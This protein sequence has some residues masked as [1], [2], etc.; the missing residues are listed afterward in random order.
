M[1]G[2]IIINHSEGTG[3]VPLEQA[4]VTTVKTEEVPV[5]N[6]IQKQQDSKEPR[7]ESSQVS[8]KMCDIC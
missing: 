2:N 6:L 7:G 1:D 5:E 8:V 3:E 4:P